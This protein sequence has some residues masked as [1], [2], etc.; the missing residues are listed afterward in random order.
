MNQIPIYD[1]TAPIACTAASDEIS[2]RIDQVEAM[3]ASLDR[4]ERTSDGLL[5]HFPLRPDIDADLSQFTVA[6]KACC[7]FWG[8]EMTRAGHELILRWDGPPDT[9]EFMDRLYAFFDGTSPSPT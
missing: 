3:R 4:V 7:Q 2:K 8:F 5:L 6:E 1:A 9:T